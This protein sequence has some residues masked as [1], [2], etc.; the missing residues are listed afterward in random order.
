MENLNRPTVVPHPNFNPRGDA[1]AIQKACKGV[2][3][4]EKTIINI[5]CRRTWK[6]RQEIAQVYRELYAKNLVDVL[7]S[8]TSGDF[9]ELLVQLFQ[10]AVNNDVQRLNTAFKGKKLD[11][12]AINDV[13]FNH[14]NA[15]L[16]EMEYYYRLVNNIETTAY[17]IR[18]MVSERTSGVYRDFL[19]A[20]LICDRRPTKTEPH[21]DAYQL[22]SAQPERLDRINHYVEIL[23]RRPYSHLRQVFREFERIAK[24]PITVPIK[25]WEKS[26]KIDSGAAKALLTMVDLADGDES[27]FADEINAATKKIGTNENK[28]SRIIISRS[29]KDLGTI[30]DAYAKKYGKT[31]EKLIE[32]ETSGD[33]KNALL[34]L[35]TGN[36]SH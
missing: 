9:K 24:H 7:K 3:T 13:I 26:G 31:L 16:L 29:E 33:Y 36:H 30:K 12:D 22:Y 5:L 19:L 2:G 11:E 21:F 6:Q 25:T 23:S 8:E 4:D 35:V 20:L 18:Q 28:L 34:A 32:S 15:D 17:P 14:D 1:E 27:Y 10:S